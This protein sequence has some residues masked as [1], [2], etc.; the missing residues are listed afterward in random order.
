MHPSLRA[1]IE[2]IS[3]RQEELGEMICDPEVVSDKAR[4]L[5]LSREHAELTPVALEFAKFIELERQR[6]EARELLEDPDMREVAQ[7]ELRELD[8]SIA[9]SGAELLRL[10]TPKDPNDD[11][12]VILEIRAGAGGDEA[13]LFV[14]DLWRMYGRFAE[15]RGWSIDQVEFSENSAGGFKEISGRVQG[16]GVYAQLKFERGV[17]RVQRVPATESQG[18]I[19]TSTATVAVMPEAEE[20]DIQL[21]PADLEFE[22]MRSSGAGGQ[23]VNTTDSAVRVTHKPTGLAV[24]CDQ[25]KSQ[26]KNR[27]LAVQRLRS[28]MLEAEIERADAERAASRREQIGTGE[29]SEKIRTYNYPQDRITDHRVSLTRHNLPGFMDGD[30]EDVLAALRSEDEAARMAELAS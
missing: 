2:S 14:A 8:E 5:G 20:V 22:F 7:S 21:D 4:F 18:R 28:K 1:K 25:E 13:G 10:L 16:R 29:R 3:E 15:R 24:R 11:K 9:A 23:H 19:H 26:V 6:E 17:H 12:N 30:I 27:E